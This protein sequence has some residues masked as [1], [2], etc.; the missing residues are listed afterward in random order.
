MKSYRGDDRV[1]DMFKAGV[2]GLSVV[3]HHGWIGLEGDLR[4]AVIFCGVVI[5]GNGSYD[6]LLGFEEFVEWID[7]FFLNHSL[8]KR[9]LERPRVIRLTIIGRI[10]YKNMTFV[11]FTTT[12]LSMYMLR[13][14][15]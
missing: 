15:I 13:Y 6:G 10:S 11:N 9:V 14:M 7:S 8:C 4:C 2:G 3:V 5:L 1:S 12:S